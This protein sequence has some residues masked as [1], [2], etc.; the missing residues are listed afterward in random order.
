MELEDLRAVWKEQDRLLNETVRFNERILKNT[1][2]QHANGIIE[3]LLK[4]EYFSLIEFAAFLVFMGIAT[5]KSMNDWR[6]LI[7]GLF[8]TA[9]L[10]GCIVVGIQSIRILN[11]ID[12]FTR[13]I[14]ETKQTI[15]RFKQRSNKSIF[16]LLIVVPPVVVTF[17]LLGVNLVRNINLLDYPAFFAVLSSCIVAMGYVIVFVFHRT[18]YL[19]KFTSIENSLVE[20]ERFKT[21]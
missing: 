14:V 5:Y 4:W 20:L 6:F 11:S 15:L 8:I 18:Y 19:R 3:N 10:A 7:S 12:L 2:S 17:L 13:S 9:F 16:A 1:F 21:E